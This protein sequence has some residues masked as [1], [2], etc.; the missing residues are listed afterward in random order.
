VGDGYDGFAVAGAGGDFVVGEGEEAG[1]K[2]MPGAR[3]SSSMTQVPLRLG[4]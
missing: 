2:S 3:S 4:R 1:A